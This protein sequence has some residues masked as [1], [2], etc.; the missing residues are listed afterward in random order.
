M[1]SY[2][3]V[4]QAKLH[5]KTQEYAQQ[6]LSSVALPSSFCATF[7][8]WFVNIMGDCFIRGL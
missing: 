4:T 5:A 1:C 8:P 3:C 6:Q 2:L 7:D